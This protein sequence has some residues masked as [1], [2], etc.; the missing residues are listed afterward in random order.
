MAAL[1]MERDLKI[2]YAV[3]ALTAFTTLTRLYTRGCL[4]RQLGLEDVLITF[5]MI[6]EIPVVVVYSSAVVHISRL[7]RDG[8][9][10]S[11]PLLFFVYR[12]RIS[13][14]LKMAFMS[15]ILYPLVFG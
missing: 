15:S 11:S 10:D 1:R 9:S 3:F 14:T 13:A 8:I 5:A 4:I 12:N 2:N 7:V 6:V